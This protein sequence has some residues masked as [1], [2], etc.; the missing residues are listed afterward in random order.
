MVVELTNPLRQ[1]RQLRQHLY[2]SSRGRVDIYVLYENAGSAVSLSQP[3]FYGWSLKMKKNERVTRVMRVTKC[4][5]LSLLTLYR[6]SYC[7][8]VNQVNRLTL[9]LLVLRSATSTPIFFC[10]FYAN[11]PEKNMTPAHQRLFAPFFMG[12]SCSGF[13]HRVT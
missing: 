12:S 1:L 4:M 7:N 8:L 10:D 9:P 13:N 2:K 5:E 6:K 3:L 11:S